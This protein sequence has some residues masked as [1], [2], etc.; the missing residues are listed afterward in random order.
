MENASTYFFI[1]KNFRLHYFEA[2]FCC[3]IP[4]TL[5]KTAMDAKCEIVV[6]TI[7][8]RIASHNFVILRLTVGN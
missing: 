5:L 8:A 2:S 7:E 6:F 1:F 4:G 3:L